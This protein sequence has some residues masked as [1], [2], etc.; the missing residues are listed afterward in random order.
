MYKSAQWSVITIGGFLKP[1]VTSKRSATILA[2]LSTAT[3]AA[4]GKFNFPIILL[5]AGFAAYATYHGET[6]KNM[7][8]L[9]IK[10][11]NTNLTILQN[12]YRYKQKSLRTTYYT[13]KQARLTI[14]QQY[15]PKLLEII[16]VGSDLSFTG[17]VFGTSSFCFMLT[18]G[19]ATYTVFSELKSYYKMK[20]M[21]KEISTFKNRFEKNNRTIKNRRAQYIKKERSTSHHSKVGL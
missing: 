13:N 8:K 15:A 3:T 21:R 12:A 6:R 17:I 16:K 9:E 5:G 1:I 10:K 7:R 19:L 4:I 20:S 18:G 11:L 2:S 14:T